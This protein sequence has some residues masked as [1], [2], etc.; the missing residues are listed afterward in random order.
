MNP[1]CV[2]WY[3]EYVQDS[4]NQ[5]YAYTRQYQSTKRLISQPLYSKALSRNLSVAPS[6]CIPP[7]ITLPLI[8]SHLSSTGEAGMPIA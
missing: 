3:Y 1:H 7:D 6:C 5:R 2:K 8:M 4:S